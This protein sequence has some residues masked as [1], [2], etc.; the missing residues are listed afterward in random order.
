MV[1]CPI[2]C[3]K[4]GNKFVILSCQCHNLYHTICIDKWIQIDNS[5]PTC[6][7]KWTPHP[8]SSIKLNNKILEEIRRRLRLES[9][10][11]NSGRFFN[12]PQ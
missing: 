12:T 3:E 5:C 8:F 1:N 9:I 11:I 7:Q 10:G 4:I 2:C 6:R